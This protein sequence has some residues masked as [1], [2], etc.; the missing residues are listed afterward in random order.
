MYLSAEYLLPTDKVLFV[1]DFLAH[2]D[3][4]AA[5]GG[6]AAAI[7]ATVAGFVF[8]VEKSFEGGRARCVDAVPPLV[9]C[10]NNACQCP[11]RPPPPP[12]P[13]LQRVA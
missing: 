8:L 2:G 12:V 11:R 6:L 7:G 5:F 3:T 10:V 4:A 13:P 9:P 1:D